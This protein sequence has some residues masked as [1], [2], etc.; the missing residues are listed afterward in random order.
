MKYF[1]VKQVVLPKPVNT[2]LSIVT[3]NESAILYLRD[4]E[5]EY[6]GVDTTDADFMTKQ[7]PECEVV[8]LTFDEA[9]TILDNS[10]IKKDTDLIGEHCSAEQY[11]TL[12][13]TLG[14]VK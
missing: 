1:R 12:L 7:H 3:N 10:R 13:K 4:G 14:F 9:K 11:Q 6:W 2:T 5:V 8:E